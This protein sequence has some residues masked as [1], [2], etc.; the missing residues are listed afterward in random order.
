MRKKKKV[1]KKHENVN[2]QIERNDNCPKPHEIGVTDWF[3]RFKII[4][5]LSSDDADFLSLS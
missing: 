5:L 3:E 2:V 4:S 1:W